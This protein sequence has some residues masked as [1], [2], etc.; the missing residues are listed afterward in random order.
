MLQ[1][2]CPNFITELNL[3][4]IFFRFLTWIFSSMKLFPACT[5]CHHHL[6]TNLKPWRNWWR[7]LKTWNVLKITWNLTDIL[8]TPLMVQCIHLVESSFFHRLSNKMSIKLVLIYPKGLPWK[9]VLVLVRHL[10][11]MMSQS[12]SLLF[13]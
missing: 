3:I 8:V 1:K 9:I 11:D 13:K 4:Y 10:I 6:L 7:D 2:Y 5:H 12:R